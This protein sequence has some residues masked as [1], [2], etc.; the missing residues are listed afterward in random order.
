LPDNVGQID[1]SKISWAIIES[2]L[3]IS[4]RQTGSVY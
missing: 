1:P 4:P 3:S 2:D